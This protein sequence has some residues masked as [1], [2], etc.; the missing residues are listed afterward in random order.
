HHNSQQPLRPFHDDDDDALTSLSLPTTVS[1]TSSTR[2]YNV[3]GIVVR[4]IRDPDAAVRVAVDEAGQC[5]D[6]LSESDPSRVGS[7]LGGRGIR[8]AG[9]RGRCRPPRPT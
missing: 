8:L 2:V 5:G 3:F 6:I 4:D 9:S 1:L 7:G